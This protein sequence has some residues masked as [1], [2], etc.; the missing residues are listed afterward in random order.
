M[1]FFGLL[2]IIIAV[3]LYRKVAKRL[4]NIEKQ[5]GSTERIAPDRRLSQL[6]KRIKNVEGWVRQIGSEPTA[7][8]EPA[9]D[10]REEPPI[11]AGD[12]IDE[13]EEVGA[14]SV[15]ESERDTPP[16]ADESVTTTDPHLHPDLIVQS[17][18]TP[19][20][21]ARKPT[22]V[23]AGARS[24]ATEPRVRQPS[25]FQ[26]RW[27]RIEKQVI[28]NWTGI[29]G[30]AV[31]VAGITFIGGYTG[32]RMS[33]FYRSLM[34][35]AAAAGLGAGSYVLARKER[36]EAL[37][38]WLR[39]AGAAVF[40]FA[41]FA[42]SAIPGLQWVTSLA[43]A[44]GILI[45]G[46][47]ANLYVAHATGKQAFASLHVVLSLIPLTLVPQ[48]EVAIALATVVA[49]AGIAM[50]YRTRWDLH[51]LVT[52]AA[53]ALFHVTWYGA[54]FAATADLTTRVIGVISAI[55]V[56]VFVALMHYRKTYASERIETLPFL[57]H[58][59]NWA[60]LGTALAVYVGNTPMRGVTLL[61]AAVVVFFLARHG[62]SLGIRWLYLTDTLIAQALA[63]V[64]VISF[65]PF[66]YHWLLV[67]A[68][69]FLQTALYL[70]IGIDEDEE[71]LERTGIYLVHVSAAVLAVSGVAA[72]DPDQTV[73]NQNAV[74]LLVG[75][76][77]GAVVHLY[78]V[79]VRGERFDSVRLYGSLE[80]SG[81]ERISLLG[82]GVGIIATAA[83]INLVGGRWVTPAGFGATAAWVL[84]ARRWSSSGLSVAAWLTIVPAHLIAWVTLYSQHP[85]PALD[86]LLYHL[87]PLVLASAAAVAF[88]SRD[89]VGH[90]LRHTAIYLLGITVAIATYTLLQPVSSLVPGVVWLSLSLLTLELANRSSRRHIA[91]LLHIGY[92]YLAFFAGAY[93]LVVLQTQ[94]YWGPVPVRAVIEGYA[95]AV[96]GFWWL[97]RPTDDLA[98]HGSWRAVHPLFLE[99]ALAFV[100]VVTVVE[101]APPWRPLFW[102]GIA[103]LAGAR[104][105]I[106]GFDSRF[107]FYALLFY[108]ISILDLVIVTS[109]FSTP[110][111]R[112]YEH[113]G[114]T[115]G[116]A[117][118]LQVLFLAT[119]SRRLG[120]GKVA[121]PRH[122]V[123]LAGWSKAIAKRQHLWL[124]YPFFVGVA[125]F[126]YWRFEAALLTLLWS[127]EAFVV[128]ALS[129]VLR[130]SHF[131]YMAL[132]GFAASVI[133]LLIID[134]AQTNLGLRG[135]VFIGV[136]LL[137]LSMNALYNKYRDRFS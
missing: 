50:A 108:W 116:L 68:V 25:P 104:R 41:S 13:P 91:P 66:V 32:L 129:L 106:E 111:P 46:V 28:E 137:M 31:L 79:R 78:L 89:G 115:G 15:T 80:P 74:L 58:L 53:F 55:T 12:Q 20:R 47:A 110:S 114:F 93:T 42:S 3:W 135:V 37:S 24:R 109:G 61:G 77:L 87:G 105:V 107:G 44:L 101:I 11:L 73:R 120:L 17:L 56:G 18:S 122:L 29:L 27:N 94:V 97:F 113:P 8:A 134:M 63:L 49:A 126:F 127:A 86:Q 6:E 123:N 21:A 70:K 7:T 128:S 48:S 60:M 2:F 100:A 34:I 84:M 4:A 96:V 62:R 132:A 65:Y 131:R 14:V 69:V 99:L 112:W 95:L 90:F 33:P 9:P 72:L 52:L 64:G 54:A 67:P 102:I 130:E 81:P 121:F 45:L 92:A 76:L 10:A 133:R 23:G 40:L 1:D 57:V 22:S 26:E 71:L 124:Y 75:A 118:A 19:T 83:L 43:P 125:L 36:W 98:S 38:Q 117:I 88:A 39:S 16:D 136:G 103:L 59:G 30:A 51:T 5:V 82:A 119:T 85:S 35:V